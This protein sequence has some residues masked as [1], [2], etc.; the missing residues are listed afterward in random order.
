M[1][2]VETKNRVDK[3]TLQK[4][5]DINIFDAIRETLLCKGEF[6]CSKDMFIP[7]SLIE[8]SVLYLYDLKSNPTNRLYVGMIIDRQCLQ[9]DLCREKNSKFVKVPKGIYDE[10]KAINDS[11]RNKNKNAIVSGKQ[12]LDACCGGKMFYFDKHDPRVLFQDIRDIETTLCDGRHFEV[13]PDV[14]ADFTNMPYPDGSFGMVVFDPPHLVYSRGKKSKMADMY[15][16]LSE[17]TKPTGWQHIKY[18]ALYSDWR[19]LLSKGFAECFRVLKPGGFLIFKWNEVD[20]KVTEILKLTSAKPIF[21]HISGKRANTHWICFLK[22]GSA[23][24]ESDTVF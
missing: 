15:G 17:K 22:D 13:K 20:I 23:F 21:G 3:E 1:K 12:I 18:G 7:K 19:D 14:Q 16:C 2:K 8:D 9:N 10:V 5:D 24:K 4:Y 11:Y 6:V